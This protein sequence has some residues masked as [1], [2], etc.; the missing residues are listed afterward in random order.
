MKIGKDK[1]MHAGVCFAATALS[2]L[3]MKLFFPF[4]PSV[5]ACWLLPAGLG[6]GKEYGDS[7]AT[8]NAWS[9]EDIVADGAGILA[10]VIPALIIHLLTK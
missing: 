9:W 2:F 10:F 6:L 8:G 4:A 3:G 7:K 5:T 1:W